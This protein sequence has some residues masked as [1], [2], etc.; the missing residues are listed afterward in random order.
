MCKIIF[1][2]NAYKH[3]FEEILSEH[4]SQ[5]INIG[6]DQIYT[7]SE[8]DSHLCIHI[9]HTLRIGGLHS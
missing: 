3:Q 6:I 4:D 7:Q 5:K 9:M 1:E 8:Y 2:R